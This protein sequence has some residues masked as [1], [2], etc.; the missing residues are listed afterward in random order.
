MMLFGPRQ[1]MTTE[2]H[3]AYHVLDSMADLVSILDADG[4]YVY[5]NA[6][7]V[8]KIGRNPVGT[9]FDDAANHLLGFSSVP[10]VRHTK[11]PVTREER[12][13]DAYF[14]VTTSP[15]LDEHEEIQAF[16][17]VY[18]DISAKINLTIDLVNTNRKMSDD[19]QFARNIQKKILPESIDIGEVH[20]KA[21]YF[22]SERLSGDFYDI[23]QIDHRIAF[24]IAD[25]MGHGVTASMLTI[26]VRQTMRSLISEDPTP[27]AVLEGL[28][29]AFCELDLGDGNYFTLFYCMYDRNTRELTY[30]NAGHS[31]MPLVY[32]GTRGRYLH[33]PGV[34]VSPVFRGI[35]YKNA[36]L[37]LEPGDHVLLYTDGITETVDIEGVPFGEDRLLHLVTKT[38]EEDTLRAILQNVT[39]FRWGEMKDDIALILMHID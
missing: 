9:T 2:F 12:I 20:F 19:I 25:V 31:A 23:L 27:G 5:A 7:M 37:T 3:T 28:R 18:R 35:A 24:Y 36:K 11:T 15:I 30:S 34:P 13:E 17:E 29:E 33:Q 21:H 14:S 38:D 32:N 8:Q 16:V 22:P 39:R 4:R 1:D 10:N 26:F 6:A